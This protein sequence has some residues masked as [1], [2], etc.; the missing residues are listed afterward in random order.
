MCTALLS[1]HTQ[2]SVSAC[3]VFVEST[4]LQAKTRH[5]LTRTHGI[6]YA[7]FIC[8]IFAS[9]LLQT[10]THYTSSVCCFTYVIKNR[11]NRKWNNKQRR[12]T[13]KPTTLI[14]LAQY[15]C[16]C[17]IWGSFVAKHQILTPAHSTSYI[18]LLVLLS[19]HVAAR[20]AVFLTL[21][22][23]CKIDGWEEVFQFD[24]VSIQ[25]L[26]NTHVYGYGIS[27]GYSRS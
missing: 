20:S 15:H 9:T 18:T 27:I 26:Q 5:T 10:Q 7:S 12:L 6:A 19:W 16:S 14:L 17:G 2:P 25:V 4:P 22:T 8:K 11:A 3:C 1:T 23:V 24:I 13:V 21:S